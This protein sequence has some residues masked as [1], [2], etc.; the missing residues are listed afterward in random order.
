MNFSRLNMLWQTIGGLL[1][2]LILMILLIQKFTDYNLNLYQWLMWLHIP[3]LFLHE[4]EE[5]VI[6]PDGF[7]KFVNT[8]TF[9]SLN[10]PQEDTPL[11]DLMIFVINIGAWIWAIAGAIF[12]QTAPWIGAG[13]LIMQILINVITHTVVFQLKHKA[14]NPGLVT[15][16]LLLIPYITFV[17]WYIVANNLFTSMNWILTFVL[18]IGISVLLPIWSITRNMNSLKLRSCTR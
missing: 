11:N 18:G 4:Y 16:L 15:T 9:I 5:Y 14:Y 12:A 10:P 8:H 2:P 1:A 13:F 7:K 6:S 3:L 17:F